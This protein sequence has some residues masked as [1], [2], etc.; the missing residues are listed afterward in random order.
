MNNNRNRPPRNFGPVGAPGAQIADL[1]ELTRRRNAQQ[2]AR[3]AAI[4]S[5]IEHPQV[6]LEVMTWGQRAQH[7]MLQAVA[8]NQNVMAILT[9]PGGANPQ[10]I[11]AAGLLVEMAKVNTGLFRGA[12]AMS[13]VDPVITADSWD[14]APHQVF[15]PE[16][17]E[18]S[19]GLLTGKLDPNTWKVREQEPE[20]GTDEAEAGDWD[21]EAG[22]DTPPAEI[23]SIFDIDSARMGI[24]STEPAPNDAG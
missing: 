9:A 1:A 4:K 2:E 3:D 21:A 19:L 14:C 24:A 22:D 23:K 7:F 8:Q 17:Y 15:K 20:L 13:T 11:A 18:V 6:L 5:A 12:V 16:Q 10:Q